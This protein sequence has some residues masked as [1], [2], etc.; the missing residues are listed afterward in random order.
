MNVRAFMES[1]NLKYHAKAVGIGLGYIAIAFAVM[2]ALAVVFTAL[3]NTFGIQ[4]IPL[5]LMIGVL[6]LFAWMFGD[7]H[8]FKNDNERIGK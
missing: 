6:I 1:L 4:V 3:I 2:S 5:I 8:M 7:M